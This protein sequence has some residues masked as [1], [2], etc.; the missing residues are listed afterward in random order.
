MATPRS[1]STSVRD[2]L[3]E[4][5]DIKSVYKTQVS[6]INPFYHHISVK[7]LIP[8]FNKSEWNWDEYESACFVRNPYDRVV[9]LYHHYLETGGR[10]APEK[11]ILYNLARKIRYKYLPLKNFTEFVK[12]LDVESRLQIP[13]SKYIQ[14]EAGEARVSSVIKFEDLPNCFND[15]SRAAGLVGAGSL[16]HKLNSSRERRKYWGYYNEETKHIVQEKYREDI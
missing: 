8:I 2:A 5:S 13:V 11:T 16:L 15:W 4:Y 7:G 10:T 14:D 3:N 1:A 9:S 12:S 6:E